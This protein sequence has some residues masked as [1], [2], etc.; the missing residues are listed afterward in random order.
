M[1]G[2]SLQLQHHHCLASL[3]TVIPCLGGGDTVV[4]RVAE[5]SCGCL[6]CQPVRLNVLMV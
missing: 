3:Q 1:Y 6:R 5:G 2:L 4:E